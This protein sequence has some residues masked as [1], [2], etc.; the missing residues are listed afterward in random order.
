MT[1]FDRKLTQFERINTQTLLQHFLGVRLL[2]SSML[3]NSS[4]FDQAM[5]T[6]EDLQKLTV[7]V[8]FTRFNTHTTSLGCSIARKAQRT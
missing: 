5:E 3:F 6:K 4:D 2:S 8:S 1:E 7:S